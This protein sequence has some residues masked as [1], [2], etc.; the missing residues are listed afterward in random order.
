MIAKLGLYLDMSAKDYFADPAPQPSLTQSIAKILIDRSP[1][2]ARLAHPRLNPDFSEPFEYE[3]RLAI[4]NAAHKLLI[5]RGKEVCIIEADDFRKTDAR[6]TRDRAITD[7]HVP[8]LAKHMKQAHELVKAARAQLDEVGCTTAFKDGEGHG[9]V[10]VAW[11]EFFTDAP[12]GIWLR[13]MIDWKRGAGLFY[14]LKTSGRSAAPQA[15]PYTMEDG[16]WPIQAAMQ[17]RG[18]D[19]VDPKNAGRRIFRFV[20]VEN[21][22]PFALTINEMT[23]AAMTHGRKQLDYAIRIWR[24]CMKTGEWPKYP[25]KINYPEVPGFKEAQWLAREIAEEDAR[26][27]HRPRDGML[28]DLSA[29]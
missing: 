20:M 4:G 29:G 8:I 5:G 18:L 24:R 3:K 23:E 6:E 21:T 25:P 12:D 9:E 17:E 13:T 2:H 22:P 28:T 10:V 1:A 26:V 27:S 11:Q 7:G 19:V 15:V 14:D 16:G